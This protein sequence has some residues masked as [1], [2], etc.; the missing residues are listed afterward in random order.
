MM[1]C[2]QQSQVNLFLKSSL[3]ATLLPIMAALFVHSANVSK[4][5]F[6][7]TPG[8]QSDLP[9]SFNFT[10]MLDFFHP[11]KCKFYKFFS[12]SHEN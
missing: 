7:S 10:V 11:P 8:I 9:V 4:M 6:S 2:L 12:G 5:C 1:T 3:L